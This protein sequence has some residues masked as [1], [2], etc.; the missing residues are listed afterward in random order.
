[1]FMSA[2]PAYGRD[3][4]NQREVVQAWNEGKDF[5]AQD[6]YG[7]GYINKDSVEKG[8]TVNIRY[9]KQRKVFPIKVK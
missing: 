8:T 4:K 3:Y 7:S 9:A 2:V 1:M 5:L 6:L